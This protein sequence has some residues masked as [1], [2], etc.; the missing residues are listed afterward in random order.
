MSASKAIGYSDTEH[1]T[2]IRK[3]DAFIRLQLLQLVRQPRLE[4]RHF[5]LLK[6]T[7]VLAISSELF[8]RQR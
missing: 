5:T 1:P 2:D 7:G 3:Q 6:A 8:A 4:F